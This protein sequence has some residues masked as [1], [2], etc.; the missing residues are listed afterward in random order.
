MNAITQPS[1]WWTRTLAVAAIAFG[2]LTIKAGGT[3]LFGGDAAREAAGNYVPFVVWFNFLAGF[4]YVVAGAGLWLQR[5]WTVWL[6]VAIAATTAA[7]F[8]AFGVHAALGG[9][10]KLSTVAAMTVRTFF[11]LTMAAI[12]YRSIMGSVR[13]GARDGS[14]S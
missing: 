2:L 10:Y 8:A 3:V 9:E 11:W 4:A 6:A 5:R 1:L 13:A 14:L 12:T 7:V